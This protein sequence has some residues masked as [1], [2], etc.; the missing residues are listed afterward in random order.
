MEA[1]AA[2]FSKLAAL[3]APVTQ[4]E[5]KEL[6]AKTSWESFVDDLRRMSSAGIAGES[7]NPVLKR[8]MP[9]Q[10][11][12]SQDEV[13]ALYAPPSF[14]ERSR[15]A[16]RHF[17]GGLPASAL[18]IESLYTVWASDPRRSP[19]S[20]IKPMHRS[21]AALYMSDLLA[22]LGLEPSDDYELAPDHISLE[23][24]T[25]AAL[26]QD[27]MVEQARSFLV[28]RFAWLT[29]YR[30]RLLELGSDALFFTALVDAILCIRANHASCD[31]A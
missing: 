11:C 22:A 15:F 29:A 20:E 7:E 26:L 28:E 30:S 27:G 6:S 31:E 19:F 12:L 10:E 14:E 2:V 1:D 25:V 23:L 17:T 8:A 3:F 18:P 24:A 21:D 16:A 5:W 13:R 9:L 4:E